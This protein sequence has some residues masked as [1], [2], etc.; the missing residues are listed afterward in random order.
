MVSGICEPAEQPLSCNHHFHEF[1]ICGTLKEERYRKV[2]LDRS[3][4]L[5]LEQPT[6]PTLILHGVRGP[7][8]PAPP[9]ARIPCCA[10]PRGAFDDP[11]SPSIRARATAFRAPPPA[12]MH[13]SER[14]LG[15]TA[16]SGRSGAALRILSA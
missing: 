14:S 1:I 6:P 16:T 7:L 15:S 2:A 9:G 5:R 4:L 12:S 10:T 11:S 8:H 3:P 13:G